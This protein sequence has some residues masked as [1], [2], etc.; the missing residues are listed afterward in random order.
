MAQVVC[1]GSQ[2][3]ISVTGNLLILSTDSSRSNDSCDNVAQ[4]ATIKESWEGIKVFDI[5]NPKS[6]R[7]VSSVETAC[8]SHTHTLAPATTAGT[9]TSTSPRTART[10]RSPTVRRRTTSSA[11]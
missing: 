3:D 4:S 7:Y 2:N 9:S 5:S 1:A 6:P 11:S 8:G 10:R